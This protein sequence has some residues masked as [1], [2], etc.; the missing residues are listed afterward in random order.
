MNKF[1]N[2]TIPM[3]KVEIKEFRKHC[4]SNKISQRKFILNSIRKVENEKAE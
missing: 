1:E 3:K 4:K 2:L